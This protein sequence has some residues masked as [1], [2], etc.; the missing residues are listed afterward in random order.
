MKCDGCGY[1]PEGG[2]DTIGFLGTCPRGHVVCENCALDD[3][4][5]PICAG[6]RESATG[7]VS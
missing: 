4:Q 1:E 2:V 5:C 7:V 6:G 3:A